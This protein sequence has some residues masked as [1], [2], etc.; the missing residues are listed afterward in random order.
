MQ[1]QQ[2]MYWSRVHGCFMNIPR[3][4]VKTVGIGNEQH[5]QK[6]A[7]LVGPRHL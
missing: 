6:Q 3:V 4:D 7:D 5:A 1:R 2:D